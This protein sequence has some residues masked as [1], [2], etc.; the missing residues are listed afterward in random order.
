MS[1]PFDSLAVVTNA[2]NRTGPFGTA[3]AVASDADSTYFVTCAHVIQDMG[4]DA[5]LRVGGKGATLLAMGTPPVDLAVLRVSGRST[6]SLLLR[7]TVPAAPEVTVYGYEVLAPG[8]DGH[9]LRMVE[10]RLDAQAAIDADGLRVDAWD[11]GVAGKNTI[12]PGCSGGPVLSGDPQ[13]VVGVVALNSHEG[14]QGIAVSIRGL[15]SLPW[16]SDVP[17]PLRDLLS[18]LSTSEHLATSEPPAPSPRARRLDWEDYRDLFRIDDFKLAYIPLINNWW[19]DGEAIYALDRDSIQVNRDSQR[20][21]LPD[22]F[23]NTRVTTSFRDDPSCRLMGCHVDDE[24]QLL[25][26]TLQETSYGDYLRSG[27]HLDD[28]LPTGSPRETFRSA[29][30]SMVSTSGGEVRPR[31][32][33]NICGTGIFVITSDDK[34]IVSKHSDHSHVYPGRWTFSA[35]GLMK[36]GA[37]PDPFMEV[38]RKTF[39]EMHHQVNPAN[40]RLVGVGADARKLYFQLGFFETTADTAAEITARHNPT[41][42]DANRGLQRDRP[43][44]LRALD[45]DLDQ[46]VQSVVGECWEPSAEACILTLCARR[47]GREKVAQALFAHQ[48]DW[49]KRDMRDEWDLR[50]SGPGDLPDMSVRYPPQ[51]LATGKRRYVKAVFD[52][53]GDEVRGKDVIEIGCGTGRLTS[54]LVDSA[55]VLTCVDL[56]ARMIARNKQRLGERASAVTYVNDFMQAYSGK[57]QVAICSQVLIHSVG[58]R[59]FSELVKHLCDCSDTVFVFEDTSERPTS[60]STSL[61]LLETIV[62]AFESHGFNL[63]DS[64]HHLLFGD[65]IA[66]LKFVR[67]PRE[68]DRRQ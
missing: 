32:L 31:E 34:I 36:W 66:F 4:D 59:D 23:S 8:Q 15:H 29:L 51:K 48:Q 3:F 44:K 21:R 45:F 20:Y 12:Q 19:R 28:P 14:A 43:T 18:S 40:V 58:E 63:V 22:L 26:I 61:R 60:R 16:D 25:T 55:Q 49:W 54:R 64:S 38:A 46:I 11:V 50:A 67:G 1:S 57:H 62:K 30:A 41:S 39:A 35:S 6:T 56:C 13:S 52:F 17:Q 5:D 7:A 68:S 27:E 42:D 37:Y 24:R 9:L 53:V 2:S 47:F 33:T 10:A 65:R